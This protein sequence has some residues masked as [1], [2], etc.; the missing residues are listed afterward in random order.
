[1]RA[2][3]VLLL[4][5]ALALPACASHTPDSETAPKGG[6]TAPKGGATV[7]VD[8]RTTFDMDIFVARRDGPVRLGFAPA[9]ETTRFSIAPGLIAGAGLVQFT[10][11]PTRG[12]PSSASD[13]FTVQPGDDLD[14]V[15]P[16]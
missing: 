5:L 1:M 14:W 10:A 3:A 12:G 16:Q 8:N 6:A 7:S 4:L 15:I 9:K 2:S 13:P 11:R